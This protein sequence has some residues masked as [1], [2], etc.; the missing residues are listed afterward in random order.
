MLCRR[1]TRGLI[2]CC[3]WCA[4]KGFSCLLRW[5]VSLQQLNC[6]LTVDVIILHM[7]MA[8]VIVMSPLLLLTGV[9]NIVQLITA[10]I[11]LMV[12]GLHC[13]FALVEDTCFGPDTK[14][15][16]QWGNFSTV[17]MSVSCS[18]FLR[19]ISHSH[20]SWQEFFSFLGG[21]GAKLGVMSYLSSG[22][23]QVL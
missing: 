8:A 1:L 15:E 9:E 4:V 12:W 21:K 20:L 5:F 13:P 11:Q 17:M 22:G 14:W 6:T 10:A 16:G 23:C 2:V 3:P 19:G 18:P 7:H